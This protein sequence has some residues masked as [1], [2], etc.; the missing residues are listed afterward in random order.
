M[1]KM[2][3]S[4]ME[5]RGEDLISETDE[6]LEITE[7]TSDGTVEVALDITPKTDRLYIRIPLHELVR[8]AMIEGRKDE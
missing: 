5:F 6:L 7:A 4:T 3:V 2:M 1:S 8:L